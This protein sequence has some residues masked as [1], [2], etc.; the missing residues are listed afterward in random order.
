MLEKLFSSYKN[1]YPGN[2]ASGLTVRKSY[3]FFKKCQPDQPRTNLYS[4]FQIDLEP[5]LA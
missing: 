2:E 4:Y 1:I 3:Q 5:P